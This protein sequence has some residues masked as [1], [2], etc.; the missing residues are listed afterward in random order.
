MKAT[1][2]DYVFNHIDLPWYFYLITIILFLALGLSWKKWWVE[3]LVAYFSLIISVTIL[4][5]IPFDGK[6]F[7]PELFWSYKVWS[8]QKLQILWNVI[9]FIPVGVVS[10]HI[11]RWRIIPFTAAFSLCIET[12]QL[13][14]RVGLFEFDDAMH[15]TI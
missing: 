10:G 14:T 13:I 4:S 3:A 12:V 6:H 5:G 9:G 15:N 8:Q 7:Q 2:I 1:N 11:F